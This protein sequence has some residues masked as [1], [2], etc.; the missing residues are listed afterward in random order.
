MRRLSIAVCLILAAA[1]TTQAWAK[2]AGPKPVPPVVHDGVKYVALNA[3]G[4]EGTVEA[5]DEKTGKKLWSAVIYK[6]KIDP[7]LEE[8]V[9]WVFITALERQDNSLL[10]TSE[11]GARFKLDLKTR[12]VETVKKSP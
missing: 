3:N 9:Q 10:V 12:N 11:K 4:R 5:R 8:D 6:V 2:R 7:R 1:V